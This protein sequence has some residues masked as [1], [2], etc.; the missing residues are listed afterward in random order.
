M[1]QTVPDISR[2]MPMHQD[3]L[4]VSHIYSNKPNT[5]WFFLFNSNNFHTRNVFGNV[6]YKISTNFPL[7]QCVSIV[8]NALYVR[9][10]RFVYRNNWPDKERNHFRMINNGSIELYSALTICHFRT[11]AV[12]RI[13]LTLHTPATHIWLYEFIS[14][15]TTNCISD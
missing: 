5:K 10:S 4:L 2:L 11:L 6:V 7:L 1:T 8:Y 9:M 12:R 13:V 3:P 15:S 14:C